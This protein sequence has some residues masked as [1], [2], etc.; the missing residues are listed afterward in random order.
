MYKILLQ[1]K[2]CNAELQDAGQKREKVA[3][4]KV[5]LDEAGML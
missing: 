4:W 5:K 3:M 1:K 2:P